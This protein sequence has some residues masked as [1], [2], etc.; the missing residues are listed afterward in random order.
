MGNPCCAYMGAAKRI[1]TPKIERDFEVDE[2]GAEF[3]ALRVQRRSA[4]SE[5]CVL[6]PLEMEGGLS[7]N[8]P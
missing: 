8:V 6:Q 7:M 3:L 2:G 4:A 1:A 5:T